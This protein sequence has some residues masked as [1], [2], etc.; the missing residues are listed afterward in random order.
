MYP[1]NELYKSMITSLRDHIAFNSVRGVCTIFS[2]I[3]R[4]NDGTKISPLQAL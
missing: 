1:E 4:R 2:N 3:R